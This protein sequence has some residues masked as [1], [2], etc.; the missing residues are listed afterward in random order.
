MK[1]LFLSGL[2]ILLLGTCLQAQVSVKD[3]SI[4]FPAFYISSSVQLPGADLAD[5]FGINSTIGGGAFYKTQSNWIVDAQYS[6][7]F[8]NQIEEKD[9][10]ANI[11]TSTGAIIGSDGRFADVRLFERGFH[12]SLTVGKLF[13]LNKPNPNSGIVLKIGPAFIQHR[14]KIDPVGGTVPQLS[15][16]YRKGYD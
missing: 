15:E 1:N 8:G 7:M 14:I 11:S 6:F 3:S 13:P 2:L 4:S 9:L 5:R 16:E 12:V 10:L